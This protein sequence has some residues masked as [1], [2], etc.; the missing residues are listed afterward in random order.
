MDVPLPLG[1]VVDKITILRIKVRR[2][3]ELAKVVQA[4]RELQALEARW[5]AAGH[6][7]LPQEAE[8]EG[9][10]EMLWEVEDR[11]RRYEAAQ[12]FGPAFVRDARSVYRL[13]DRRAALKRD[14]ST[15]LGSE[16]VEVKEYVDYRDP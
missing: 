16:L 12:D 10:N 2:I 9:V 11:L 13:N 3:A 7:E 1:D 14:I 8:L 5:R 6:P 15:A 4:R